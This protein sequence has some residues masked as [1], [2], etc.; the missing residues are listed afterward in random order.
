MSNMGGFG[1]WGGS[2]FGI[3]LLMFTVGLARYSLGAELTT[4]GVGSGFGCRNEGRG[5]GGIEFIGGTF[6]SSGGGG[7]GGRGICVESFCCTCENVLAPITVGGRAIWCGTKASVVLAREI[8][9]SNLMKG[10]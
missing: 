2:R 4:A 10:K 9:A 8:S 1:G 7:I 5:G 3:E 6:G